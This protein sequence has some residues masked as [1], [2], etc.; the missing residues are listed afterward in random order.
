MQANGWFVESK[1][2]I[3]EGGSQTGGKVDPLRFLLRLEYWKNGQGPNTLARPF[4]GI[5]GEF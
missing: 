4:A 2:R 5:V 3:R 1:E